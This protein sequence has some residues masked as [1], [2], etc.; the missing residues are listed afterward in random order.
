LG[1]VSVREDKN[2]VTYLGREV[3][4][5]RVREGGDRKAKDDTN[6][7]G[8]EEKEAGGIA[9]KHPNGKINTKRRGVPDDIE[10]NEN[11]RRDIEL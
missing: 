11:D 6:R 9:E 2:P 10:G 3:L 8:E 1:E 5:T 7:Q 4:L